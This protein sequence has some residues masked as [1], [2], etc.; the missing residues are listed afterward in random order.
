MQGLYESQIDSV[1]VVFHVQ[2]W[3]ANLSYISLKVD[4]INQ[5]NLSDSYFYNF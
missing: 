4:E 5:K 1:V 3:D 2:I